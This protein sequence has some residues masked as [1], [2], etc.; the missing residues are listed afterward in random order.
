[1]QSVAPGPPHCFSC[2][3]APIRWA[4]LRKRLLGD[5]SDRRLALPPSDLTGPTRPAGPTALPARPV[6]VPA[7]IGCALGNHD[8]VPGS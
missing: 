7:Q 4:K 3:L 1:M 5:R 2:N 8:D 6:P